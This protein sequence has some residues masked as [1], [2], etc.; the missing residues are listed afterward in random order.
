[1]AYLR[2]L[3]PS[4]LETNFQPLPWPQITQMMYMASGIDDGIYFE[5]ACIQHLDEIQTKCTTTTASALFLQACH[6][7]SS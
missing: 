7:P 2:N 6:P 3:H 1:M 5:I 4:M